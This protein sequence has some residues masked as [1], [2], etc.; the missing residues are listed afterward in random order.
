M[1][2]TTEIDRD[3]DLLRIT[4]AK[5][6]ATPDGQIIRKGQQG[7]LIQC[8]DNLSQH[9]N[10]WIFPDAKAIEGAQVMH[11]AILTGNTTAKGAALITDRAT[12]HDSEIS[13]QAVVTNSAYVAQCTITQRARVQGNANARQT[14]ITDAATLDGFCHVEHCTLRGFAWL[15]GTTRAYN[16]DIA[17]PATTARPIQ[18]AHFI[19]AHIERSSHYATLHYEGRDVTAMFTRNGEIRL[20]SMRAP[21]TPIE[22]ALCALI[23][24]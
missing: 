6:F 15:G 7:G 13:G 19:A 1:K 10:C 5:T 9:G 8:P 21:A 24:P 16:S 4:A 2:Y 17:L 14:T 3:T 11:G 23:K 20:D 22:S 18:N 12:A